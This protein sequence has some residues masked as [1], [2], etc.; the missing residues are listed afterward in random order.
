M[1]RAKPRILKNGR[2]AGSTNFVMLDNYIF[3]CLAYRTM[4][5]GPRALL[6]ELI[7][8]YNGSNN[9]RIG[10]GVRSAA[11]A[12]GVSKDTAAGYFETLMKRGFIAVAR[13]GGF[14]MKDPQ[15]RRASEWR[16]TWATTG[17]M[18]ATKDFI[19]FGKKNTI[20]KTGT[21][22]P[23]SLDSE[24]ESRANCPEKPD[25]ST[26]FRQPVSPENA[27]TCISGHRR[28]VLQAGL[29]RPRYAPK[30]VANFC[31]TS[32]KGASS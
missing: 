4:K 8:L 10:L 31:E 19:Q 32:K 14:N 24:G 15:S 3:D 20:R 28:G 29:E 1:S 21:V 22:S 30:N 17:C 25:L 16:L 26:G 2:N 6:W 5:P 12:L 9:G 23:K 7:R 27:D 11:Q 13:S 18:T